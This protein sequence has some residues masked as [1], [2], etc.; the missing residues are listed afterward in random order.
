M[1]WSSPKSWVTGYKVLA[2]DMN[3]FVSDNDAALRAGGV[4]IAS[5]AAGD[6]VYASSA[7]Q[8]ARLGADAGKFLKSGAS[9]VSWDSVSS[10]ATILAKTTT[11]AITDGNGK[12][13][14]V[15][16]DTSGGA[17]TLTLLAAATAAAGA[18]V[19]VVKTTSDVNALTIDAN[20]SETINGALTQTLSWYQQAI[21]LVCDGSN[22]VMVSATP[23][24]VSLPVT[25]AALYNTTSEISMFSFPMK[26]NQFQPGDEIFISE[27]HRGL[28]SSGSTITWSW[29]LA[30][31]G[32]EFDL[33]S[34]ADS[35]KSGGPFQGSN[36]I[37]LARSNAVGTYGQLLVFYYIYQPWAE[38]NQW[39][40]QT[41]FVSND[42]CDFTADATV[43]LKVSGDA[44]S[45]SAQ[46]VPW[47]CRVMHRRGSQSDLSFT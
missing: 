23:D 16:A 44:A 17:W 12:D 36:S 24:I 4:A 46:I 2:S 40:A 9:S 32:N 11:Y 21:T 26:A 1:G 30:W 39:T 13:V 31:G 6:V 37:R 8:L 15:K 18:K 25:M 27:E 38:A 22:W 47:S 41:T 45:T 34:M 42:S 28:Q 35:T 7:T 33:F 10:V 14:V 20:G 43:S 19:V 3:T 5:Q 29:D